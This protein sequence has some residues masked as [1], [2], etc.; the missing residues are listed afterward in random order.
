MKSKILFLLSLF[1]ISTNAVAVDCFEKSPSLVSLGDDYYGVATSRE[2][3]AKDKEELKSFYRALSGKWEG[4]AIF[5]DCK[6]SEKAPRKKIKNAKASM[7]IAGQ[8]KLKISAR[9]YFEDSDKVKQRTDKL[10]RNE[11]VLSFKFVN[12]RHLEYAELMRVTN[13]VVGARLVETVY[14]INIENEDMLTFSLLYYVNG[15][16]IGDEKWSMTRDI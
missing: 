13:V 2:I 4:R 8:D 12:S 10:L 5:T 7:E 16:F 3:T 11:Q 15:V 6:G 14:T 9:M 1:I